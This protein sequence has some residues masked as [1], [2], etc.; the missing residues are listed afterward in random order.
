MDF[1]SVASQ[2]QKKNELIVLMAQK[3]MINQK[4]YFSKDKKSADIASIQAKIDAKQA[5]IDKIKKS[6][7]WNSEKFG[8]NVGEFAQNVGEFA[9]NVGEFGQNVGKGIVYTG[10]KVGE[11]IV[12]T[13]QKVGEGL[14]VTRKLGQQAATY[15]GRGL[16]EEEFTEYYAKEMEK[17]RQKYPNFVLTREQMERLTRRNSK[18]I[19]NKLTPLKYGDIRIDGIGFGCESENYY[20]EK[21]WGTLT[22]SANFVWQNKT[23][24]LEWLAN[25]NNFFPAKYKG[26]DT[27]LIQDAKDMRPPGIPGV[28]LPKYCYMLLAP[29]DY[30]NV[31][32]INISGGIRRTRHNRKYKNQKTKKC[33][34]KTRKCRK[35]K[36]RRT[37]RR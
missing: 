16:N 21:V 1:Y 31:R 8:K 6:V 4:T 27:Y 36:S 37:I 20:N 9:Q 15:I 14:D 10:Q 30:S 23:G 35:Q 22:S 33:N 11:G 28:Q 5:E 19:F 26:E 18:V 34:Q 7:A 3:E 25:M 12:Y 17:K 13:G 32:K 29:A 24:A 2:K